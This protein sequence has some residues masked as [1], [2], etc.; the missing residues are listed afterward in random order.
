MGFGFGNGDAPG[1]QGGAEGAARPVGRLGVI[2]IDLLIEFEHLGEP[3]QNHIHRAAGP[4]KKVI[5]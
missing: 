5:C 2:S 3:S 4:G 1:R